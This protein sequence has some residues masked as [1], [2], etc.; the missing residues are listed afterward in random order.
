MEENAILRPVC[1]DDPGGVVNPPV[2][3]ASQ[4][5]VRFDCSK[6]VPKL[7]PELNPVANQRLPFHTDAVTPF[8]SDPNVVLLGARAQLLPS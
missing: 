1:P 3:N 4:E 5:L 7:D 8:T 2:V 6:I